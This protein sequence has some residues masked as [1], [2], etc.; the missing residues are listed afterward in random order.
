MTAADIAIAVTLG[1]FAGALAGLLGVGGGFLMVPG[2]V[3]LLGTSQ[4][5]AQGTS[6]LVIIPTALVGTFASARKRAMP[7]GTIRLVGGGGAA[8]AIGGVLIALNVSEGVLRRIFGALLILVAAR[9][10]RKAPQRHHAE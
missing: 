9:M 4:H 2:M 6:L 3:V 7:W 1:L 10:L 5:V 8:G